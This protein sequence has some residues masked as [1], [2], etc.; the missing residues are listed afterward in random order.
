MVSRYLLLFTLSFQAIWYSNAQ[1]NNNLA[2]KDRYMRVVFYNVENLFDT[3]K[4]SLTL[5]EEFLPG[6]LRYWTYNRY[7]Q[8]LQ[9]ISRV[10]T[11]IGGWNP[12][13]IIGLCE[14]ENHRVLYDL[15]YKSSLSKLK[16]KIIH[17]ESPDLRGIDVAL[18]YQPKSFF[19]ISY[20]AIPVKFPH[21]PEATTR[22]ILYV[23]GK[24]KNKDTIHIFVNHWPSRLGGQLVSEP[25]R[26][27][28]A[29]I[30][31]CAVD[32][33]FAIRPQAKIIIL[34]DLNDYPDN[35]SLTE[36]LL[37]KRDFG[38]LA[39]NELYNLSAF[40]EKSSRIGS[41]KF[42]GD[43]GVLDQIIVSGALLNASNG[44]TAKKEHVF[45]FDP[46]FLLEDDENFTGKKPFRTYIG[47]RYHGGYSDHLPVFLD[48][49]NLN[50]AHNE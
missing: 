20:K 41:H 49:D 31:R 42:D 47:Y 25:N 11:S 17:Q 10:I 12:P 14:I 4:D 6:G 2:L 32:S 1:F 46:D 40:L 18:L 16:Y 22:D 37:A 3:Q 15:C 7:Q 43:W 33:I 19:P 44:L 24:A 8:K 35:K 38:Q 48:L 29:S 27:A 45:I 21:S 34:G 50:Q 26:I 9:N 5:D 28:A 39:S 36:V 30:L 23:C 13:E